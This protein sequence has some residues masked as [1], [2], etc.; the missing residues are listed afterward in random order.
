MPDAARHPECGGE[1]YPPSEVYA[2]L[3]CIRP[4]VDAWR[5]STDTP[6]YQP[7]LV[8]EFRVK[9]WVLLF[10][11]ELLTALA[12]LYLARSGVYV[13]LIEHKMQPFRWVEY[14]VTAS[15]MLM[16]I[17]SLSMVSDVFLLSGLFLNSVFMSLT[18]GL[19]FEVLAYADTLTNPPRRQRWRER[20]GSI[21]WEV[22][23]SDEWRGT[24]TAVLRATKW[25]MFGLSWFSFGLI[26]YTTF[27]AFYSIIEPYYGYD[28]ADLWN[29]LFWFIKVLNWTLFGAFFTFPAVHLYQTF[30]GDY[31]KAE[32]AYIVCSFLSKGALVLIIFAAAIMRPEED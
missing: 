29:E 4:H 19:I 32:G 17:C 16:C 9:V 27:D 28:S 15:I 22:A 10:V 20:S 11:F 18:G 13:S 8:E 14:S 30:G 6:L 23:P 5:D 25:L 12:H 7:Q 2:W 26:F 21:Q 1:S 24:F 3:R 31:A